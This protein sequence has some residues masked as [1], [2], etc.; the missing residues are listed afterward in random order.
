MTR[1]SITMK[2]TVTA[3]VVA[4]SLATSMQ[5]AVNDRDW[6]SVVVTPILDVPMR[7][8][9]IT[10]GPDGTCYMT[11][12]LGPDFENCRQIKLWKS[13]D[14]KQWEDLGAVWDLER[15]LGDT[16]GDVFWMRY[17]RKPMVGENDPLVWGIQAPEIH[18]I[19]DAWYLC[20]S[21]NRQGT[22][23]LK[24]TSGKPEGPYTSLG[25]IT[26]KGGDPSMFEDDDGSVYWVFDGGWIAKLTDD[27]RYLAERPRLIQ[28]TPDPRDL[29]H[30]KKEPG[31][32]FWLADSPRAVG[33][34]GAFLFKHMG[35]Y[36]LCAADYCNRLG[37]R[38]DDTWIAHASSLDGPWS[39]RQLMIPHGGGTTV[40][41]GPNCSVVNKYRGPYDWK[42]RGTD[43]Q[44]D[45]PQLYATFY[46]NDPRAIFRDRP[47]LLPLEF[48]G[49]DRFPHW[50]F[51]ATETFPR[52]PQ[53]VFTERGAWPGMKPLLPNEHMR[54]MSV[55]VAPDG[56]YYLMGSVISRPGRLVMWKSADLMKW[57]ETPP[58]WTYDQ[59]EWLPIR[60]PMPEYKPGQTLSQHVFWDV[61]ALH[62][63]GRY[64][65]IFDTFMR[66]DAK[67][68]EEIGHGGC[69]VLRSKGN[70][71]AGPYES[72]GRIGGQL[73]KCPGPI[74]P[75]SI[76]K[77]EDGKIYAG[78]WLHWKPVVAEADP[79]APGWKWNYKPKD[80]GIF[81]GYGIM[82]GGVGLER[83][84]GVNLFT[85]IGNGAI[86]AAWDGSGGRHYSTYDV[87]YV[88]VKTPWGPPVGPMRTIPHAGAGNRFKD[89]KG[90]WWSTY[91]GDDHCGPW[92]EK[93]GL[94]PLKVEKRGPF[95]LLIDIEDHPDDYQKRVMGAGE[96]AE[97]KTV[98]ETLQL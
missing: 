68:P 14:L 74:N 48:S 30:G 60:Y 55:F 8:T 82:E 44:L 85:T 79:E 40:F 95:D 29:V 47:A 65:L 50:M 62:Y 35:R 10:A 19:K 27:L 83:V 86:T 12:T 89:H 51:K 28:P 31:R 90:Y 59:I 22:G 58:V 15:N 72:L 93:I 18:F 53:C 38:C 6:P 67:T 20:F 1:I 52:K 76:I 24:S 92:W 36:Y 70:D 57:E 26:E 17:P 34:R 41:L 5:A 39:E 94:M 98:Q 32:T 61:H 11:G 87:N 21:M 49:H 9:A 84:E 81:G 96:I 7:D 77:D 33:E 13:K 16:H 46:G 56:N 4:F 63:E 71:I 78:N 42:V 23:L 25:R 75:F 66:N 91:F 54:D 64:Y 43:S 37:S 45:G 2:I 73:G 88:A 3:I 80:T 97:V 69:G